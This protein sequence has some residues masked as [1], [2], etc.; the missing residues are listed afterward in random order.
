MFRTMT[1]KSDPLVGADPR[2][3]CGAARAVV[4]PFADAHPRQSAAPRVGQTPAA[5]PSFRGRRRFLPR[6][7]APCHPHCVRHAGFPPRADT[8]LGPGTQAACAWGA[9]AGEASCCPGPRG[10]HEAA[11]DAQGCRGGSRQGG[12]SGGEAPSAFAETGRNA[13]DFRVRR[14]QPVLK[15]GQNLRQVRDGQWD[16]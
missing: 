4:G 8:R 3:W 14:R 16:V 7:T 12:P 11:G 5:G 2:V 9:P 6:V 15:R 10:V 1:L 13:G